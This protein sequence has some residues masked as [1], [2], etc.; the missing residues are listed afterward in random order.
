MSKFH[1]PHDLVMFFFNKNDSC[2]SPIGNFLKSGD[3]PK[4]DLTKSN[5]KQ[6]MKYKPLII[7][8]KFS[9]YTQI[10]T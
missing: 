6:N 8:L 2:L 9:L 1:T 4:R 5:Y 3:H 10:Q 7:L